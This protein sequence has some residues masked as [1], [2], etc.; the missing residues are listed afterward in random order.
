MRGRK[1]KPTWLKIVA[2]NPGHRPLNT[3]EPQPEGALVDAP[4]TFTPAQRRLWCST[5]ANV[6]EGLLRKLDVGIFASYI[7]NFAEFLEADRRVQEM[8]MVVRTPQGQPM[9]NPF[10][11]ARNRANTAMTKAASELG[12]TP[13]SRSRV[14]VSG[15][16]KTQSPFGALKEFRP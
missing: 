11:T 5:L 2:G 1:P 13:S 3:D 15:K 10:V 16:K 6:P 12:F 8:G 7:V 4:E 9:H 14:K